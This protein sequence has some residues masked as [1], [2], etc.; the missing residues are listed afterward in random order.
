[1]VNPA[2][3]KSAMGKKGAMDTS[4]LNGSDGANITRASNGLIDSPTEPDS[5]QNRRPNQS[6]VVAGVRLKTPLFES[7]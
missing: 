1:M 7:Q 6:A 2:N 4:I 3:R 5:R